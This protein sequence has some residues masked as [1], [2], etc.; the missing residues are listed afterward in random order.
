MIRDARSSD[1]QA[2]ADI[3][4]YY[5]RDTVISFEAIEIGAEEISGRIEKVKSAGLC[6]LVLEEDSRIR[7]YAYAGKWNER[8]AY[9]NTA[10]V[11]IYLDVQAQ[12]L[13]YGSRLYTEL[14]RRL[15]DRSLH[16]VIAGI[17]L[18][19]QA[20]IKLHEKFGMKKVAH[21]EEVGYK[22]GQWLDVGYWQVQLNV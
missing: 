22:F 20:S 7:G 4:N 14:F 10:E 16:T 18:P 21:F 12:G 6:W 3:Y 13:G 17:A 11:S 8:S 9:S 15:K 19:N 5:I 2:I 1:F